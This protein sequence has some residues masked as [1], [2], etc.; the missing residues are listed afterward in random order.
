MD[1]FC[2]I[3]VV[4]VFEQSVSA[5]SESVLEKDSLCLKQLFDLLQM[6]LRT[7]CSLP[8][9]NGK[10]KKNQVIQ[11]KEALRGSSPALCAGKRD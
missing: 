7:D 1:M 8:C 11:S 4:M 10:I 3:L 5:V 2:V 9:D 6:V